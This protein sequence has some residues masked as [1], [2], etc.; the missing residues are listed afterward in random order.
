L[1][2][3]HTSGTK[4]VQVQTWCIRKK[5]VFILE[6]YF[7]LKLFAAVHEAFNNVYSDKEVPNKTIQILGHRKC[8][9]VTN[10]Y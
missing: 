3:A 7:V 6:N 5:N 4:A 1:A 2:A 9:S 10:A 8:L